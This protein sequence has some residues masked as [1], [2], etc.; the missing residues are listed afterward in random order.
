[1]VK[2]SQRGQVAAVTKW[3]LGESCAGL[4]PYSISVR[5]TPALPT[6][7]HVC[8]GV[9]QGKSKGRERGGEAGR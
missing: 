8:S 2:T 3:G 9:E 6:A 7:C 1:M 4:T 5:P